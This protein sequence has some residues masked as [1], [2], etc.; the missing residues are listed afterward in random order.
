M[1]AGTGFGVVLHGENRQL[2]VTQTFDR[3]VVEVY[4]R[5]LHLGGIERIKVDT[6]TVILRGDL[7][8]AGRKVLDRLVGSAMAELEFVRAASH[9]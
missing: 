7:D 8:L 5:D 4:M 2:L 9:R 6:E 1:R 3:V